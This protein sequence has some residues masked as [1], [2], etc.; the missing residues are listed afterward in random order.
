MGTIVVK[1]VEKVSLYGYER[2]SQSYLQ[3][4]FIMQFLSKLPLES[5]EKLVNFQVLNPKF[6]K[7]NPSEFEIKKL[8]RLMDEQN[9]EFSAELTIEI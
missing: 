1:Q 6:P 9:V 2:T 5:L 4:Q 3:R 8:E 7:E